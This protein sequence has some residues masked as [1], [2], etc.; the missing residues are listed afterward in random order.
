MAGHGD[1]VF[2]AEDFGLLENFAA[3][4]GEREA[5]G[6]RIEIADELP[7]LRSC[8]AFLISARGW[9]IKFPTLS[10]PRTAR[11]GWGT[12]GERVVWHPRFQAS[13]VLDWL[14]GDSADAGLLEREVDGLADFVVVQTFLES[15]HQV[16][17][18]VIAIQFFESVVADAAK[19]GAA[20][21][22]QGIALERIELQIDFEI[23]FVIRQALYEILFLCDADSVGVQHEMPD[24]TSLSHL[25]NL[26]K[27]RVHRGLSTGELDY[28]GMA[29][30]ADDC[31]Q[32]FF[33]LLERAELVALRAAGG[34]ADGTT[35]VAVIANLNQREAGVLLVVGA[36]AA[37]VGAS[38]LHRRVVDQRHFR[39]LDEN[40]AAAAVVVDVVGNEDALSAMLRAALEQVDIAILKNSLGFDLVVARRADRYGYV[41]EKV[42]TSL[43]HGASFNH[44][45]LR[46]HRGKRVTSR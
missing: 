41:I 30:V 39:G 36:E 17:G 40:L 23:F 27:I 16:R 43:G 38:P 1:D 15:D 25:H 5:I 4:L 11:P 21:F 7:G 26:K 28:I 44:S 32:H 18:D 9:K 24:G 2:C 3:D 37:V 35:Q 8:L 31:V 14:E 33:D 20:E 22:H 45:G 10:R 34:V 6:C 46:G 42:G 19:I 29:F 13:G 12:L